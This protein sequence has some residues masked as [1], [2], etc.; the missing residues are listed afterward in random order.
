MV[1]LFQVFFSIYLIMKQIQCLVLVFELEYLLN[2]GKYQKFLISNIY[3]IK[4]DLE[5]FRNN[6]HI[7]EHTSTSDHDRMALKYDSLCLST[8][9]GFLLTFDFIMMISQLFINYKL[10]SVSHLP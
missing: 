9:D 1:N 7:Y 3:Q 2:Y 8:I 5:L 10:K 4:H 6:S